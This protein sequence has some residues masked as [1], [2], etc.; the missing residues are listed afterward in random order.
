MQ[1]TGYRT[2]GGIVTIP[3]PGSTLEAIPAGAEPVQLG[4]LG[5]VVTY[6]IVGVGTTRFKDKTPYALAVVELDE[7][8]RLLALIDGGTTANLAVDAR[9][10]YAGKDAYGH[11]FELM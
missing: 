2:A 9:V 11:H 6:T 8:A 5:R 4:G 1:L 3:L 10:H 7:G